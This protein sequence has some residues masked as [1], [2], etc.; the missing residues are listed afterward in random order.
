M[1]K[2]TTI[3]FVIL[4]SISFTSCKKHPV[5]PKPK[6]T[7]SIQ[8]SIKFN[9]LREFQNFTF[10]GTTG[11]D[12]V[13]T[14]GMLISVPEYAFRYENGDTVFTDIKVDLREIIGVSD[15]ILM[16]KP[17][18]TSNQPLN[19]GGQ[20]KINFKVN[21]NPV[22]ISKDAFVNVKIPTDKNNPNFRVYDGTEDATGYVDWSLYYNIEGNTIDCSVETILDI[23]NVPQNFYEVLL[24][25]TVSNW[26]SCGTVSSQNL[27]TTSIEAGL[28]EKFNNTNTFFFVKFKNIESVMPGY[29]DGNHFITASTLAIGSKV[30]LVFISEVDNNYYSKFIDITISNQTNKLTTTL[31][32]T[33]YLDI[34]NKILNL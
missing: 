31:L 5:I 21:S 10:S 15:M 11:G 8:D 23:N 18:T 13:S 14:D 29:F 22:F 12:F 3:L 27:N 34:K 4:L 1:K 30:T 16:N 2:Y 20:F 25:S 26:I 33:T 19:N 28:P 6:P 24:D 7:S 9:Y 32:S 17:S